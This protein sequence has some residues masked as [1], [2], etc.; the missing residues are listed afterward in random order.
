MVVKRDWLH[1]LT[2][3]MHLDRNGMPK[4]HHYLTTQ[5][6]LISIVNTVGKVLHQSIFGHK[7]WRCNLITIATSWQSPCPF[8][9]A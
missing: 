1:L 8:S 5:A 7:V 6:D 4:S 9:L 3:Q 2:N